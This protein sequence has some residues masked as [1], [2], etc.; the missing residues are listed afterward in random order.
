MKKVVGWNMNKRE[1]ANQE[2]KSKI[3][4]ALFKLLEKKRFSEITVTDIIKEAGV[5]RATYYRNFEAKEDIIDE[6]LH[7]FR[8]ATADFPVAKELLPTA[9]SKNNLV[10]RLEYFASQKDYFLLLCKNGFF[11]FLLEDTNRFAEI[12]LGNMPSNSIER[13]NIYLLSGAILNLLLQWLKNDCKESPEEIA[14]LVAK[15]MPL[16]LELFQDEK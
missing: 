8:E 9:F 5:A 11:D 10:V 4:H 16:I 12:I 7:Q 15:R 13:Y 1:Q 14:G 2:S 3:V 6:Y